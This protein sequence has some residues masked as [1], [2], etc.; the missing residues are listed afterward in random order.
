MQ[1]AARFEE[2]SDS[3]SAFVPRAA[4]AW[5]PF[6]DLL[7]RGAWSQGFRAPNLIQINDAGTTRSNS[8]VQAVECVAEIIQGDE[9]DVPDCGTA[10]TID[11]RSGAAN[12]D[13]EDTESINF[14]VV[15][16]PSFIPGLT[17][18]A[19]YWQV[20][21]EGIIGIFGNRN[22][23]LLDL[24]LR[25]QGSSN[26]NVVRDAPDQDQICLLY[27]SPSPRDQRGSRMPSSA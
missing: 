20:E 14:G 6:E 11:F 13:P 10:G 3:S 5:R 22:S 7:F 24:L 18:T 16:T 9:D 2:F 19:D 4:L 21:Q 8:V 1:L 23:L 25:L 15:L 26:P 27:T 12:L 17:L